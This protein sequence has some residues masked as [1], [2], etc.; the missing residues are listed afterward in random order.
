MSRTKKLNRREFITTTTG[1]AAVAAVLPRKVFGGP[2]RVAPSDRIQ[3]ALIGCGTQ[4]LR[5]LMGDWLPREDLQVTAICDPNMDSEDYR[6][7]SPHGL[8]NS[9][10][11]FLGN[12]NWGSETGI[13]AGRMAAKELIEGYYAKER[14][15]GGWEGLKLYA[16]YREMLAESEGIDAIIDMTPEH[17]HG[18]VNIAGM[19]AGKAVVSHKVLAN[20]LHE[21][22]HTVRAAK[23]TGVTTHLMAWNNDPALYQL[24]EWLGQGVIG[25]VKEVHNWSNRPIWPQGWIETPK[26]EMP[27]P[28]GMDWSLWLGC[29][30][31][32]P[33]HIDYTHALFRGWF[34]FGSGCLG[35]MGQYSLWRTYRMLNPGPVIRVVSNVATGAAI[36]GNQSQWRRS[37]VAFPTASTVHFEHKDLDIFWYDGGMKPR[38]A[39]GL[40]A[41]GERLPNQGVLYVGEYGTIIGNFLG[42]DFRLL[43]E[44]RMT[45]LQGSLPAERSGEEVKNSVDEYMDAIRDGKQSRGSFIN[46]ADLAEATCLG[47]IAIRTGEQI[48]WD[49]ANMNMLSDHVPHEF[50]TRVYREGWAV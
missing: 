47:T 7:W 15:Q 34:E 4:A 9:V 48:S 1:T 43:P 21:V 50:M 26:E 35:D 2:G 13:R 29:V 39:K 44:S 36:V 17:L 30:P 10:R 27:I 40:L 11:E 41:P 28:D 45:A 18:V 6:D 25:K 20:T 32:R 37:E 24:W 31:D 23:E 19:E 46:I 38:I 5:Q 3:V 14:A 16:D 42:T 49:A 12:S 33:Y 22:H 8:R